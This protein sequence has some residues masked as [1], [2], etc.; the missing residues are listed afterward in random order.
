MSDQNEEMP[1]R[2]PASAAAGDGPEPAP[3]GVDPVLATNGVEARRPGCD[4]RSPRRHPGAW[5]AGDGDVD[6]DALANLCAPRGTEIER[7]WDLTG[8]ECGVVSPAHSHTQEASR[9]A[10]VVLAPRER[11]HGGDKQQAANYAKRLLR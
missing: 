1:D 7:S 3:A 6:G 11:G 5:Q 4:G 2:D 9:R 10:V 8:N